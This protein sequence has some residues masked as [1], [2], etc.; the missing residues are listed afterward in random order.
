MV[1]S[2][3][4]FAFDVKSGQADLMI[5]PLAHPQKSMGRKGPDI[6]AGYGM[7]YGIYFIHNYVITVLF[8]DKP[9]NCSKLHYH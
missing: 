5:R 2:Q 6:P 7:Y 8:K 4:G 3:A 1:F 9:E